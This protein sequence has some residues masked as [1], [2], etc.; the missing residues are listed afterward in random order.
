VLTLSQ[1]LLLTQEARRSFKADYRLDSLKQ[2]K[3]QDVDGEFIAEVGIV[4]GGKEPRRPII[5]A[6][7]EK[8]D[9]TSPCKVSCTC[10][11]FIYKLAVPLMLT[12][13]TDVKI[14]EDD[15]P[16]QF[17][18]IQEPGLCAH[19]LALA[20]VV[21]A[22]SNTERDRLRRESARV[23]ISDRLKNL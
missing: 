11:Y 16:P 23:R 12:G 2:T 18:N 13:S 22:P 8:I 19:L 6:Y 17:K 21:L 4:V 1:L 20:E 10:K 7:S 15:I 5:R 3:G 9:I 14:D